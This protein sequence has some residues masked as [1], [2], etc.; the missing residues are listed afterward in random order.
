VES[1]STINEEWTFVAAT[2]D[3]DSINIFVNGEK[4]KI[5]NMFQIFLQ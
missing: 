2:F 5:L 1:T 3:G 4:K